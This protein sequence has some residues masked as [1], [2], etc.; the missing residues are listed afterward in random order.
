MGQ[1]RAV[2]M[3][4]HSLYGAYFIASFGSALQCIVMF[5]LRMFKCDLL[6]MTLLICIFGVTLVGA[7]FFSAFGVSAGILFTLITSMS[8]PWVFAIS[9]RTA[10]GEG[11]IGQ[12]F[13]LFF[14]GLLCLSGIVMSRIVGGLIGYFAVH[15]SFMSHLQWLIVLLLCTLLVGLGGVT[16]CII[17]VT[18]NDRTA[19]DHRTRP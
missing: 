11:A 8:L 3:D 15:L 1:L 16:I 2:N 13:Q 18:R 9:Y 19:S 10:Q 17:P 14:G 5:Y 6:C 7:M 12:I 4:E